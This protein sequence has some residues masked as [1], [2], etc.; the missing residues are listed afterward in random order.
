MSFTKAS[1]FVSVADLFVADRLAHGLP[2]L[3]RDA[4][5]D[6]ARGDAPRLRVTDEPA[7]AAPGL[8][9]DLGKLRGLARAGLAAHDDHLVIPDRALDLAGALRDGKLGRV[10]DDRL[11]RRA[12]RGLGDR[13]VHILRDAG[14]LRGR[15]RAIDASRESRG[16]GG[17]GLRQ[18]LAELGVRRGHREFYRAWV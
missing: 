7:D 8:E 11:R 13:A 18:P 6:G 12:H 15:A 14:K 9:A 10:G 3:L 2:Q 17:H 1:G 4:G 16:I 5:R